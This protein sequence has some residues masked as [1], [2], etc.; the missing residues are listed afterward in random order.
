MYVLI[1]LEGCTGCVQPAIKYCVMLIY[2]WRIE[3]EFGQDTS[4]VFHN[5]QDIT[6]SH[7]ERGSEH[8]S[9]ET[10]EEDW[11]QV[12]VTRTKMFAAMYVQLNFSLVC[13]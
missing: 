6:D 2:R 12:C 11:I 3:N 4:T 1:G 10:S 9:L 7:T 8:I 5:L 13:S